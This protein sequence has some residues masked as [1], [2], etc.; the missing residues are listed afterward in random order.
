MLL[1]KNISKIQSFVVGFNELCSTFPVCGM[2]WK[3]WKGKSNL[4]NGVSKIPFIL[5]SAQA[6]RVKTEEWICTKHLSE[7]E[8]SSVLGDWG[9]NSLHREKNR[10]QN[11]F[12]KFSGKMG[13]LGS[14]CRLLHETSLWINPFY[15]IFY[16]ISP[17]WSLLHEELHNPTRKQNSCRPQWHQD[18]WVPPK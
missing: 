2:R 18:C 4:V 13:E 9:N 12:M 11:S 10:S 17:T 7:G 16:P 1:S 5:L 3:G 8:C 6:R 14:E 15:P